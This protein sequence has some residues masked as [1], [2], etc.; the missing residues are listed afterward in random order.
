[1][2]C[3]NSKA[4]AA[5][6]PTTA[7][8]RREKQAEKRK[9]SQDRLRPEDEATQHQLTTT[10]ESEVSAWPSRPPWYQKGRFTQGVNI[11]IAAPEPLRELYFTIVARNEPKYSI[12][13]GYG[14][15]TKFDAYA[16]RFSISCSTVSMTHCSFH[17][18]RVNNTSILEI[19]DEGSLNGTFVLSR[20]P[21]DSV[22][23]PMLEKEV[24]K[25]KQDLRDVEYIRLGSACVLVLD[26]TNIFWD[27]DDDDDAP[28]PEETP[29]TD[30]VPDMLQNGWYF[31]MPCPPKLAEITQKKRDVVEDDAGKRTKTTAST[32]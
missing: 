19:Q 11:L 32:V 18:S 25:E 3:N 21:P 4:D 9:K 7:D 14:K 16:M 20:P 29:T 30:R 15:E 10:F 6:Q 13:I 8:P 12:T 27:D 28:V 23:R 22:R 24:R 5:Q 2:G 17:F 1:M 31:P 26:S